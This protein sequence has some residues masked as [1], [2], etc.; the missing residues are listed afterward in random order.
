M[1]TALEPLTLEGHG[2]AVANPEGAMKMLRG[3]EDLSHGDRLRECGSFSLEKRKLQGGCRALSSAQKDLEE[4]WR[5]TFYN[6]VE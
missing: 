5:G 4:N 6:G 1:C 3:L 2:P